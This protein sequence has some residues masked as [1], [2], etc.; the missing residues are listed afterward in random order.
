M[1]D[2]RRGR[3]EVKTGAAL[4]GL[5]VVT[6]LAGPLLWPLDPN[7]T[8]EPAVAGLAPPGSRFETVELRDGR[9]LA[10][11]LETAAQRPA[12]TDDVVPGSARTVRFWLGSDRLGRDV[13]ARLLAGARLS[14]VVATAAVTLALAPGIPFGLLAGLSRGRA[15]AALLHL[16]ELAQAFPR[17]FLVVAFAAIVP[18]SAAS[19]IAILAATSWMPVARLVRAEARRLRDADFVLAARVAGL[20][21]GRIAF[22]HV[23]PNA[24]APVAVEASLG[25]AAAIASEAALSF[26]GIGVPPPAASWGNLIADGRDLLAEAPWISIAPGVALA[27]AVLGCNLLAEGLRDRLDPRRVAPPEEILPA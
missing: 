22:R 17:L 5:V 2:P 27:A 25:M 19:T 11:T 9:R 20:S 7:R 18:P 13:A 6:S 26:L 15:G 4:L 16:I 1:P 3:R 23:L 21:P 10:S 8:L 14:L 24:L 12:R